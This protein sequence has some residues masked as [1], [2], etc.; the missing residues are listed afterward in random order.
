MEISHSPQFIDMPVVLL[1]Q[2]AM[3]LHPF[4]EMGHG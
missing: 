1:P 2:M 4:T 3:P